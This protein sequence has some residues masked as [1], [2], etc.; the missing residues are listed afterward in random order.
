VVRG[1]EFEPQISHG[2]LHCIWFWNT[3]D[4]LPRA[5]IV[6]RLCAHY[7]TMF[8][9]RPSI[10]PLEPNEGPS[11]SYAIPSPSPSPSITPSPSPTTSNNPADVGRD[12]L[13][14]VTAANAGIR[15]RY[16]DQPHPIH[17]G[18]AS[19]IPC[20]EEL[21]AAGVDVEFAHA[22]IFAYASTLNLHR[23]PRSLRYFTQYVIDRWNSE[24]ARREANAYQPTILEP[25]AEVD[26]M[27]AFAIRYAREGDS[28]YQAYCDE[29]GIAWSVAA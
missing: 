12:V 14:L 29:R 15:Q 24:K 10:A 11:I 27:R 20:A 22:V 26:Q 21:R 13:L 9:D 16:G 17:Y 4:T 2:K 1:L 5:P 28:S 18:H 3:V 6:D 19:C 23:P 8:G 7:R 25:P